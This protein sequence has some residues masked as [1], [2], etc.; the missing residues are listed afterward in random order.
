MCG[1]LE[2]D[3]IGRNIALYIGVKIQILSSVIHLKRSILTMRLLHQKKVNYARHKLLH[4]LCHRY[5]E[6]YFSSV[7]NKI[8]N[9][10]KTTLK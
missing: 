2:L 10:Y 5:R 7:E 3:L 6:I 9:I 1:S 4:F 8:K